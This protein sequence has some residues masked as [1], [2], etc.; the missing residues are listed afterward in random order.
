ALVLYLLQSWLIFPGASTQGQPQAFITPASDQ[1]L[2]PLTTAAGDKTV[3]LFAPALSRD[4]TPHPD[5][6]HR[7]TLLYFYGNAM[8]LSACSDELY[9]FRRLG[10]NVAIPE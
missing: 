8:T 9:Q 6:S 1:Q 10:V 2:I 5:A 3:L 4:G 7:P